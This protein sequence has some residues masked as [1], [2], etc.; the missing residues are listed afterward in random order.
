MGL[1]TRIRKKV[2]GK[3]KAE[4]RDKLKELHKELDVGLRPQRGYDVGAALEDW[5]AHGLEGRS[6]NTVTLYRHAAAAL[7]EQLGTVT[8]MKLTAVNVQD[9]L[10]ALAPERSTRTLKIAHDVLIRAIRQA[11]RD[12]LVGRNV[13]ALVDTPKGQKAGRPSKSLTLAQTVAL[14]AAAKG[15]A[16]E[17]YIVMSLLSGV[18]TKEARA[19]RWDPCLGLQLTV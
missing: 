7:T 16:L 14:M 10:L 8:L 18:R 3:T 17:A 9:A 6:A 13:A 11:E 4:V 1:R 12:D 5:L 19:L 15:T 2:S